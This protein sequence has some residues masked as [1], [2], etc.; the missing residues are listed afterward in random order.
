MPEMSLTTRTVVRHGLARSPFL[1]F[2][3]ERDSSRSAWL[4]LRLGQ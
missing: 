4:R 1:V 3:I 2:Y